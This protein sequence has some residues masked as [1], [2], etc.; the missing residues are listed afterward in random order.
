MTLGS[1]TSGIDTPL[2]SRKKMKF[3]LILGLLLLVFSVCV[4]SVEDHGESETGATSEKMT[5]GCFKYP[6]SQYEVVFRE[7][8]EV[9]LGDSAS[10]Y[11][12]CMS[13]NNESLLDRA[14]VSGSNESG[15]I[16]VF[17]FVCKADVMVAFSQD[18]SIF[19]NETNLACVE[20]VTSA[21]QSACVS[22][23]PQLV[24]L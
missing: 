17:E 2:F 1:R 20:C 21:G 7:A 18:V 14:V 12:N 4:W 10:I 22:R 6:F 16:R 5:S 15:T 9:Q 19:S 13:F 23:K 3:S 24:F 11:I 8:F